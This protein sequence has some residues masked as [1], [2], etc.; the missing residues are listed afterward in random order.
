MCKHQVQPLRASNSIPG[1]ARLPCTPC[2]PSCPPQS[3]ECITVNLHTLA[4]SRIQIVLLLCKQPQFKQAVSQLPL[5][6][7]ASSLLADRT[8]QPAFSCHVF[9]KHYHKPGAFLSYHLFLG[10]CFNHQVEHLL[11]IGDI[12]SA[13]N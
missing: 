3:K 4:L 6:L 10:I 11:R 8:F 2:Q 9:D 13:A 12:I 7:A 5:G 1:F